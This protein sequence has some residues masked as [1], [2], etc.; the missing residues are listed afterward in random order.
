MTLPASRCPACHR[1]DAPPVQACPGCGAGTTEVS[2]P[3]VATVLART[4]LPGRPWILLVELEGQARVLAQAGTD[5]PPA[6]GDEV[7]L[8]SGSDGLTYLVA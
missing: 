6:I 8:A 7:A 4:Q 5:R 1:T 2:L 3:A